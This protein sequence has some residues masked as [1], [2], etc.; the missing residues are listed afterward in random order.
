V[1]LRGEPATCALWQREL[2]RAYRPSVRI[3]NLSRQNGLAGA[4]AKP[5]VGATAEATA[6]VCRGTACLPPLGTLNAL[7]AALA[8]NR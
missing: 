8:A 3:L 2:E 7:E 5:H 6:W 1:L 4:L